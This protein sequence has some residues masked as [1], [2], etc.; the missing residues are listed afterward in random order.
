MPWLVDD[1]AYLVLKEDASDLLTERM[2]S[3]VVEFNLAFTTTLE[4]KPRNCVS[5]LVVEISI[6]LTLVGW[7]VVIESDD[8]EVVV[9]LILQ[10]AKTNTNNN[11][12]NFLANFIYNTSK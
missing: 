11:A 2:K 9:E 6:E 10:L 12:N 1:K 8:E 3:G 7:L 4:V 5:E